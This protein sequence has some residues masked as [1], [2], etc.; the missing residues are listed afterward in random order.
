VLSTAAL[1]PGGEG[2]I[3]AVFK[4]KGRTGRQK[5]QITVLSNDP[6]N[7]Q[8]VLILEGEVVQDV[9]VEPRVVS[10]LSLTRGQTAERIVKALPR[11][12]AQ[13]RL[14]GV[15]VLGPDEK[16][17]DPRFTAR[18][19]KT[20]PATGAA[21]IEVAFLGT[22]DKGRSAATLFI[23]YT[24]PD[25]PGQ[26]GVALRLDIV[27]DLEWTR[28]LYFVRS[29]TDGFAKRE[30]TISSR[31]GKP[32]EVLG[33]EDPEQRL[34]IGKPTRKN[35]QV[36]IPVEIARPDE[37][38]AQPV[39][40]KIIVRTSDPDDPEIKVSYVI[41]E[42]RPGG[43]MPASLPRIVTPQLEGAAGAPSAKPPASAG[44]PDTR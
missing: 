34:R 26:V 10:F 5:K 15:K 24:A 31:T 41:S 32:F 9:K 39:Q 29:A 44:R 37:K 23:E 1:P 33:A 27:G 22:G 2:E 28:S 19:L 42:G 7:P 40:K 12:P 21:E 30:I 3:K 4:S 36:V 18:I 16:T 38:V 11:D 6:V 25:G 43:R 8:L 14:G 17:P 35:G 20:D 13:V